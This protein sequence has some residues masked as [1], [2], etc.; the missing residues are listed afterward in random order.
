[1]EDEKA[2][3]DAIMRNAT[4]LNDVDCRRSFNEWNRVWN[5]DGGSSC[6]PH[7]EFLF[8]ALTGSENTEHLLLSEAP[9]ESAR[10]I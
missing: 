1:M 3:V 7:C 4:A 10:E 5:D 2:L 6:E 9:I 8:R